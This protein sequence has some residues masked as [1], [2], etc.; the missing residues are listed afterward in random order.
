MRSFIIKSLIVLS[1]PVLG[2]VLSFLGTWYMPHRDVK[3]E[4]AVVISA[5]ELLKAFITNEKEPKYL[6]K[7]VQVSGEVM[8]TKTNQEGKT[9]CYLKTSDPFSVI[10]CTFKDNTTVTAGQQL[11]V[12]GI[13]TGYLSGADVVMIDCFITAS[14]K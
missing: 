9:V 8:E 14:K 10:N 2:G 13:C 3:T 5:D 11:T 4:K 1:L 12:T 7:A 6:D